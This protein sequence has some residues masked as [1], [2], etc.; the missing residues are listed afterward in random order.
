M[1]RGIVNGQSVLSLVQPHLLSSCFAPDTEP[2]NVPASCGF[3]VDGEVWL[4]TS[5]LETVLVLTSWPQTASGRCVRF[6][7]PSWAFLGNYVDLLLT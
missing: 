3:R 1:E 5:D 4:P 7:S 6:Q 2:G